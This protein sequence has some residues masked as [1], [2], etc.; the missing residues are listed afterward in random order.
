M[1]GRH[2]EVGEIREATEDDEAI[3]SVTGSIFTARVDPGTAARPGAQLSLAV[4]P[5]RFHYFD[6]E[7]GLRLTAAPAHA[8]VV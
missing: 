4:D 3:T 6:P 5:G 7:T 8:A 1:A 2:V